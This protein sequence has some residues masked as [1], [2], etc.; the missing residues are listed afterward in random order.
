MDTRQ[1]IITGFAQADGIVNAYLADLSPV[2]MLVRPVPG[3]NHVAWQLGHLIASERYLMDKVAPGQMPALPAGFVER[4]AKDM[5]TSDKV[6]G[7]LSK[8]EYLRIG[9]EVRGNVLKILQ[10]L[11]PE[12]FD[13]PVQ[14]VPP[15]VKTAGETLLFMSGHWMM[16]VGQWAVVRRKVGRPPLF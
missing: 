13:R 6:E 1:A 11:T 9:R 7:F 14:G 10:G 3:I 4:H 12:G 16:H 15:F 5:A 2:E 8:E